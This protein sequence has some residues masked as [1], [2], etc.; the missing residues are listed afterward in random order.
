MPDD[1]FESW[2]A[3]YL[4]ILDKSGAL[5]PFIL[6]STQRAV[7]AEIRRLRLAGLPPR[8][9]ILKSRQ[10][11]ISTLIEAL[12]FYHAFLTANVNALVLAHNVRLTKGLLR[13]TRRFFQKLPKEMQGK[14][15]F[16]NVS[17]MH[18]AHNDSRIQVETVG[19]VRGYSAL[20]LHLSEFAFYEDA[21][22]TFKAIMQAIPRTPESL[23]AIESTANGVGNHYHKLWLAAV[24]K[25]SARDLSEHERG[26]SP[27]FVPWFQHEE[28][29]MHPWFGPDDVTPFERDLAHRFNLNMRQLAWRRWCIASNCDDDER[30]FNVEYP[31]TWQDAFLMTGRPVFG[32]KEMR[33]YLSCVPP[34]VPRETLPD[35]AEIAWDEEQGKPVVEPEIRGRFRVYEK[36]MPRHTYIL[37]VDPSEGDPGSDPSPIAVLDQQTLDC[38]AVW[39][40]RQAPDALA[41]TARLIAIWYNG[42]EIIYEANNHGNS[43]GQALVALGYDNVYFRLVSE[44]S[45]SGEKTEK[46]GFITTL[47]NKHYLINTFRRYARDKA[48]KYLGEPRFRIR[49]P[50]LVSEMSTLK[51]KNRE[52]GAEMSHIEAEAGHHK[53]VV[54]AFS[55]ALYCHRG[56]ME[57]PL[58]P[59]PEQDVRIAGERYRLLKERDP[60]GASKFALDFAGM[61][62]QEFEQALDAI[63]AERRKRTGVS[64][65]M[66]MR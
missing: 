32:E 12:I 26:W 22:N 24:N 30:V 54:I 61:S 3:Q 8:I 31:S 46:M 17:E 48:E 56:S 45:V 37:G 14:R 58:E 34:D 60:D 47:K 50:Q 15:K 6:N 44:D 25:S 27:I 28:Y 57:N 20:D 38:V 10:V 4:R 18:F 63:D 41:A 29:M 11:G 13:M 9:I 53:D 65:T 19:E 43:F 5:V 16:D 7:L 55:L 23:V 40:G 33:Y 2:A 52:T 62:G 64:L 42:A 59:V 66:A 39:W 36:P 35:P 51:Y 21:P 1:G 49:D